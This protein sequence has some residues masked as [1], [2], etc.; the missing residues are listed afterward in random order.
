MNL[1]N[2]INKETITRVAAGTIGGLATL[3]AKKF[4]LSKIPFIKDKELYQDIT[5]LVTGIGL[6]AFT[7]NSNLKTAG[8]GMSLVSGY[9]IGSSFVKNA[10]IGA[11]DAPVFMG[12]A[13]EP[14]AANVFMGEANGDY[15]DSSY[16]T[17]PGDAG[18]MNY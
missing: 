13:E 7:K 9:N 4:L 15:T 1:S 3:P 17:T 16:D 2:F 11:A 5:L 18:E 8:L 12:L 10:G 14:A 6:A